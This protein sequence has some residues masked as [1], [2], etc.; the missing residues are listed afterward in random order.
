MMPLSVP[1][2]MM[3]TCFCWCSG[4]KSMMRLM[5]SLRVDGVQGAHHEVA[6]LRG[7]ERRLDR[8]RVAHLADED[9]V[10]VL[11]QHVL[12]RRGV[13]VG[14][15]ADL[16]LVDDRLLV[17]VQHL[18]GVL[19]GDDVPAH[20]VVDVVD[21]RREG[22]GL[23]GAGRAGDEHQAARLEREA[24][25]DVGEVQ[26]LEGG[27]LGRD[28]AH[29]HADAAA[30][31]EHVDAEAPEGRRRVGEVDLVVLAE[32]ADLLVG[33]DGRRDVLGVLGGEGRLVEQRQLAVD[34]DHRRAP[35]LDVQVRRVARHHLA[36]QIID[37][38]HR[39]AP[40]ARVLSPC[41]CSAEPRKS[42]PR[43]PHISC[44]VRRRPVERPREPGG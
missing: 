1:A 34:A 27:D 25:D 24:L 37:R 15:E 44:P 33:H 39:A 40:V 4:K 5:V 7:G 28:L 32:A 29:G 38:F 20:R 21:H 22:G 19:D 31:A 2:S 6:G 43:S 12:E 3:R 11:A 35:R 13:G 23:A 9:V 30:L 26:L 8:S 36:E 16:A 42:L 17:L 14:V 18:D 10:G 41:P